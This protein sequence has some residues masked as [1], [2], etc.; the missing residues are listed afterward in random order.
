MNESKITWQRLIL[1]GTCVGKSK[2][3]LGGLEWQF[4]ES[5]NLRPLDS[6]APSGCAA[7]RLSPQHQTG[8]VT[9]GLR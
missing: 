2:N 8:Q 1:D 9:N 5:P 6:R 3:H 7:F 4:K